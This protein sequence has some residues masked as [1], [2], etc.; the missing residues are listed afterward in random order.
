MSPFRQNSDHPHP[1]TLLASRIPRSRIISLGLAFGLLLSW[2]PPATAVQGRKAKEQPEPVSGERFELPEQKL[3]F[4]LHGLEGFEHREQKGGRQLRERWTGE[5][6]GRKVSIGYWVLGLDLGIETPRDVVSLIEDN[7]NRRQGSDKVPFSF[8]EQLFF[9]GPYGYYSYAAVGIHTDYEGTKPVSTNIVWGGRV[10]DAGYAFDIDI[11]PAVL[12]SHKEQLLDC[13]RK[14]LSYSGPVIDPNWTDEEAQARWN[15]IAPDSLTEKKKKFNCV[16]TDHYVILT[17]MKGNTPKKFG[18]VMEECYEKI[19]TIFPFEDIPGQRLLPVY[20]FRNREEYIGFL[21]K[22]IGWSRAQASKTA[23]VAS[24]DFYATMFNSKSDP[25][26]IHEATHQI[27]RNRLFLGGGGSW[28]Q[29][30]MAEYVCSEPNEFNPVRNLVKKGKVVPLRELVRMRSLLFSSDQDNSKGGSAAGDAYNQAG[31]LI[32]FLRQS[33]FR[34]DHFQDFVREVGLVP[35]NNLPAVEAAIF[36]T[37]G[38][39]LD[40]LQEAF[41]EYCSKRQKKMDRF[42][43]MGSEKKKKRRR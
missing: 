43:P 6:D 24:R 8:Q 34:P 26:H 30:G 15:E 32:E 40:E 38:V 35:R 17:N 13:L 14:G 2:G 19:R 11:K 7:E 42:K 18:E 1:M 28:F 41:V 16:R 36:R 3:V 29:E 10:E 12:A 5:L 25:V 21:M 20:L 39:T 4:I 23:G 31:L 37:L 27:F 22:N 9:G 33:D